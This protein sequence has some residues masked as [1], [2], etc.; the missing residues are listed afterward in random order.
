MQNILISVLLT[1]LICFCSCKDTNSDSSNGTTEDISTDTI[2]SVSK[3]ETVR[4]Y[5]WVNKLRLRAEPNTKSSTIKELNEGEEMIFTGQ[6]TDFTQKIS[7]RG[8]L[9]DEPWLEVTTGEGKTG[10]VYGGG[11]KFYQPSVDAKPSPYDGC[12]A[13]KYKDR[14]EQ[15]ETCFDRIQEKQHQKDKSI[16]RK[17]SEGYE[18]KLL[19]GDIYQLLNESDTPND[20]LSTFYEYCYYIPNMGFYV[21]QKKQGEQLLSYSLINDKSGKEI[22]LKDYPK[23]APDGKHLVCLH[24]DQTNTETIGLSIH[25]FMSNGFGRSFEQRTPNYKP[26]SPKW[27]DGET[28]EVTLQPLDDDGFYTPKALRLQYKNEEWITVTL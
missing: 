12:L 4:V 25:S 16:V 27:I 18:I 28:L 13:M 19:G 2:V 11:V 1:V 23:P 21:F 7:L 10:W 9:F 5:A 14:T 26:I 20:S 3:P 22:S 15:Y 8:T 6:K 24:I 17:T